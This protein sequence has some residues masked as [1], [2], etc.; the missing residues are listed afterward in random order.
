[1]NVKDWL[2]KQ[3]FKSEPIPENLFC[4]TGQKSALL[5]IGCGRV[6]KIQEH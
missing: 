3:I 5:D 1:M 6:R 2:D 4:D